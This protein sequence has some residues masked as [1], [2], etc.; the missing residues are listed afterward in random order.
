M[1][2]VSG[3]NINITT[4][5]RE[6]AESKFQKVFKYL[7][8]V[9]DA[10]IVLSVEKYRHKADVTVLADGIKIRG[11]EVTNDVYTSIDK[12]MDKIENQLKRYK[13]KIQRHKQ[14]RGM[15]ERT[16]QIKVFSR[17]DIEEEV[18]SPRIIKTKKFAL[19]PMSLDEAVMQMDL[20]NDSFLV[21]TNADSDAINVIYKRDDGTIGLIEPEY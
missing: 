19:K 3:K 6:Y 15:K 8:N 5:L 1:I 12:V 13:E 4:P 14:R 11:E 9:I 7:Y 20:M 18:E 21:F 16:A 2:T 10:R 17:L